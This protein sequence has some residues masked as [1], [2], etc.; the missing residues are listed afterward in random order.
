MYEIHRKLPVHREKFRF[1][2]LFLPQLYTN[3]NQLSFTYKTS[4][5]LKKSFTKQTKVTK[6]RSTLTYSFVCKQRFSF[7]SN[8][9]VTNIDLN[10]D[11]CFRICDECFLEDEVKHII[12][13]KESGTPRSKQQL[14]SVTFAE[15]LRLAK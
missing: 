10:L 5:I 2:F 8:P 3:C 7:H 14:C 13:L 4:K 9:V 1:L 6:R 15:Y 11:S 12:H